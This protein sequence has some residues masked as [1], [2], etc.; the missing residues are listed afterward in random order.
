MTIAAKTIA[1]RAEGRVKPTDMTAAHARQIAVWLFAMCGLLFVMV[2]VGGATRLT[3]SGLSIT[4]WRPVTGAI[5]PLSEAAWLEEMEKYRQIPEYQLINKGMSMA[6]F[7]YIY[8]WE[9]GHRFLGRLIGL[10]FF[11]PFMYFLFTKKVSGPLVPKLWLMF[12]LGGA[13]GALGW[14]M[15]MS[16]LTERV[17]VSQYRLVAHLGLA[18]AIFAFIFWT[19]LDLVR[20]RPRAAHPR[21]KGLALGAV[22]IAVGVYLQILLG[23]FVAGLRA[24]FTYNTWPL[25]DGQ[26]VPEAYF[27]KAPWFA[28]FFESIAAVQFNHRIGAYLLAAAGVWLWIAARRT[29]LP[30]ALRRGADVVFAA[31]MAQVVLGIWTLVAG[32]P[33]WLGAAHQAGAL[34]VLAAAL[35]FAHNLRRN[36]V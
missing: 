34:L 17:D 26:F 23:G 13:Q 19:A 20:P 5:P 4:E 25:M 28:N 33:L 32:V 3:D 11:V 27:E 1:G 8:W 35:S 36:A 30:A 16:G 12:A 18:I 22:F 7:K 6:E 31:I 15:V 29:R 24:G 21:L 10:A 9:W 14:F 2:V